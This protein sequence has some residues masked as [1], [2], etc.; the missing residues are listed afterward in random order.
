M[1][2]IVSFITHVDSVTCIARHTAAKMTFK[3]DP[4]EFRES[5]D[6]YHSG[7]M[8]QDAFPYLTPT[9]REVLIAG[10]TPEGQDVIYGKV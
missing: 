1:R 10:M 3:C 9:E 2:S 7:A 8:V 5:V 6:K 4:H